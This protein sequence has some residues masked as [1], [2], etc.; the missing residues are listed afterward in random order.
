MKLAKKQFLIVTLMVSLTSLILLGLLYYAMPIYY[1]QAKKDQLRQEYDQVLI[2]LEGQDQASILASLTTYDQDS[3]D[4][5]LTLYSADQEI[6]Y[7][8]QEESSQERGSSYLEQGQY[9]EIGSWSALVTTKE[10]KELVLTA[11]YGFYTL[12]GV[13]QTL[14]TLYPFV[15][16]LIIALAVTSAFIYSGFSTRRIAHLSATTRQMQSLQAGLA[17]QVTGR[18]EIATLAQDINHLYGKLQS[19][20]EE[21]REENERSLVREK[22][23]SDFLRMTSHELK[24][25]IASMTG[26][27]EGMLYN[28]GEF[29]DHQTYLAKCRDILAEQAALV[30]SI[31]EATTVDMAIKNKGEEIALHSLLEEILPSYVDWALLEG[32]PFQTDLEEVF[33]H[34]NPIYLTK[35]LKNILDNAFRYTSPQASIKLRLQANQLLI[36][37]QVSHLLSQEELDQVFQPFYRPDYSRSKEDG[38]TGI[39]L[40]L[41]KQILDSHQFSYEFF[42]LDHHTMRFVIWF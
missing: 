24:T 28:V 11:E 34:G 5:L 32:Y 14:L 36:D 25:P 33:I 35:A 23:K 9:D 7:P 12:S 3:P 17:C 21:L 26:L 6:I 19:S 8:S 2:S 4:L 41:V 15:L 16:L 13:S 20:I 10:G 39:G 31:L 40:Y 42:P 18:D 29:K 22:E 30:Q 1:N 37:N 27:V 38:G